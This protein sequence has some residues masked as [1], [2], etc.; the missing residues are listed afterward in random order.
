MNKDLDNDLITKYP[1]IFKELGTSAYHFSCENGWYLLIDALCHHLTLNNPHDVAALQ[2]KEKFG[3]LRFH[4][5]NSTS[6]QDAL[7]R[8]A[9]TLSRHICEE[10]GDMRDVKV[11]TT[12]R[13]QT[14][15]PVC[16]KESGRLEI[17][18]ARSLLVALSRL[19]PMKETFP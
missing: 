8:F 17:D 16:A 14:L 9:E 19:K 4:V 2:V 5:K 1:K 15:C 6:E 11:Y 10:C 13:H 12:G 18:P 3:A 7:I